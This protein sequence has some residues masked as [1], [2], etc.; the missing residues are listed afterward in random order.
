MAF[1]AGIAAA[2]QRRDGKKGE[3]VVFCQQVPLQKRMIDGK[4]A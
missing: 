4:A 2:K 3:N 1:F